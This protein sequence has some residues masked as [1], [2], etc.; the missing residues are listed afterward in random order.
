[1]A[2]LSTPWPSP[3]PLTPSAQARLAAFEPDRDEPAGFC[4]PLGTPRNTLATS[5]PLEV[6]QQDD[7][8]YF[9]FQPD[10]L[11]AETRRVYLD[12]RPLPPAE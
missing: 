1:M 5:S 4:M 12:K 7:R 10:L 9:V 6:L 3:L 2:A 8:I 11:N